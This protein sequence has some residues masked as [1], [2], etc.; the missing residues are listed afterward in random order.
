MKR[1]SG[2]Q[3]SMTWILIGILVAAFGIQQFV[4]FVLGA[5]QFIYKYVTLNMRSF[6][7]GY[8]WSFLTAAFLH[9]GSGHLL[10]N[11]LGL[12][13]VGRIVEKMLSARAYW[14][15]FLGAAI[16]GNVIWFLTTPE[17]V[18]Y[19]DETGKV[20][21]RGINPVYLVGASGGVFGIMAYFFLK[22]WDKPVVLALYFVLPIKAKSKWFFIVLFF[23]QIILG[24]PIP[25][26]QSNIAY[27][28]HAGGMLWAAIFCLFIERDRAVWSSLF[29][30]VKPKQEMQAEGFSYRV[31]VGAP[32]DR[33][34]VNRILDK[35]NKEGI[36]SLTEHERSVLD[37]ASRE[38]KK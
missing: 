18:N 37:Q 5:D 26:L 20:M 34:E 23:G 16:L 19:V 14:V 25:Y 12:Y 7:N 11:C 31:N 2:G 32:V 10:A 38:L 21:A 3:F 4:I 35:L 17:M 28:A 30:F 15:L 13:F 24:L 22:F 9:G 27:F 6:S 8:Y 36:H 33:E 29:P 1:P